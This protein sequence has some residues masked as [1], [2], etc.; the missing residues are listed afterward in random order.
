MNAVKKETDV[1]EIARFLWN[2]ARVLHRVCDGAKALDGHGFNK[3]DWI[4]GESVVCD[5]PDR[6]DMGR[7]ISIYNRLFKYKKQLSLYG[8]DLDQLDQIS[9]LKNNQGRVVTRFKEGFVSIEFQYKD[10]EFME[11][12]TKVK[13]LGSRWDPGNKRWIV[14]A[15]S[16]VLDFAREFNFSLVGGVEDIFEKKE[17]VNQRVDYVN[18]RFS[19]SFKYSADAVKEIKS[20]WKNRSWS[21]KDK[22]WF[23]LVNNLEELENIL[24]F[25]KKW[26]LEVSDLANSTIIARRSAI[27]S[28]VEKPKQMDLFDISEAVTW[29]AD[30][31][32]G[33]FR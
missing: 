23:V 12:K 20:L 31:V 11:I 18:G 17:E 25:A 22:V 8:I 3:F 19:F 32:N 5:R 7:C 28:I 21:W 29:N 27:E 13:E 14:K 15:T 1:V 9:F 24:G 30:S 2:A 4:W 16:N 26:N 33:L 10:S 6:W